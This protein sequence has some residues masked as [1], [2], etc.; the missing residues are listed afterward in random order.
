MG[1]SP[2]RVYITAEIVVNVSDARLVFRLV[3][4]VPNLVSY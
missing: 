4:A 2:A 3:I 1:A